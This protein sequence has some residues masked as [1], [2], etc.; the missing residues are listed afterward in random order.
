FVVNLASD[1][2]AAGRTLQA[3]LANLGTP[4]GKPVDLSEISRN[5]SFTGPAAEL[6]WL[7]GL[8]F[9][10]WI[11]GPSEQV[12]EAIVDGETVS[13]VRATHWTRVEEDG[14]IRA[15]R[16]VRG[17]DFHLPQRFADGCVHTLTLRQH[18]GEPLPVAGTFVAFPDGL[19][20]T[21]ANLGGYNS[22]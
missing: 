2:V 15:G 7:G 16:N 8:R 11:D 20:Q 9:L 13:Q 6:R 4:I 18:D 14:G 5:K 12:F 10:G 1:L 22:E 19:A 17:F 21:L 3:R